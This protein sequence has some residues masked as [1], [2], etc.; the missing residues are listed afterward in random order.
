MISKTDNKLIIEPGKLK[1]ATIDIISGLDGLDIARAYFLLENHFQDKIGKKIGIV[2]DIDIPEKK[3]SNE[4]IIMDYENYI[5]SC[6]RSARTVSVYI[7][8]AYRLLKYLHNKSIDIYNITQGTAFAYLSQ[9]KH[10]R[11]LSINSYSRLVITIKGFLSYLY[12]N[13]VINN[14]IAL[15]LK[16]PNKVEKKR[17]VLSFEDIIKVEDYL[18]NRIE[19]FKHENL[20]DIIIFYFGIKCGLRKSEIVK[21]DWK[22]I[23]LAN[24]EI[25]IIE[26]KGGND[27]IVFLSDIL[28]KLLLE[29]KQRKKSQSG[30]V[31]RGKNGSRICS[32]SLHKA[33]RR[34]YGES[35]VYR[36]GLTIHSLRHTYAET[37]RKNNVDLPTIQ[38]L[39]GHKSLETTAKYLHVTKDDLKKAIV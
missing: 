23:D 31:V 20:R 1:K 16:T 21:L 11:G 13:G 19:K 36:P 25:K 5:I 22:D 15:N 3:V 38:T 14:D 9:S 27:R 34:L 26:S 10:N 7:T 29:Y 35:G 12:K 37:L 33:I 8:E 28:K 39:L 2:D 24:N 4:N 32:N 17:E 18:K 30:E 6:G